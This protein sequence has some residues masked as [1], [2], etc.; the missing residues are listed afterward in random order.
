MSVHCVLDIE[1]S[2]GDKAASGTEEI[3]V[4]LP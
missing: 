3:P 1:L 2:A 4:S